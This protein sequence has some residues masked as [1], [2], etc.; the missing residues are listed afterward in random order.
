MDLVN[1]IDVGW[2]DLSRIESAVR[3]VL[4]RAPCQDDGELSA[5]HFCLWLMGHHRTPVAQMGTRL[6]TDL[7]EGGHA[8]ATYYLATHFLSGVY[9]DADRMRANLMLRTLLKNEKLSSG[10]RGRVLVTLGGSLLKGLGCSPDLKKALDLF[11]RAAELGDQEACAMAAQINANGV[12]A[13]GD[14]CHRAP[15]L[16]RAAHFYALGMRAGNRECTAM[17]GV[18]HAK[19]T[20][21]GADREYGIDLL[22]KAAREGDRYAANALFEVDPERCAKIEA[23]EMAVDLTCLA[24]RVPEHLQTQEVLADLEFATICEH[25][26]KD[27]RSPSVPADVPGSLQEIREYLA[28]RFHEFGKDPQGYEEWLSD[29]EERNQLANAILVIYLE[30]NLPALDYEVVLGLA[31][32]AQGRRKLLDQPVFRA[33]FEAR[34]K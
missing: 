16:Q 31:T 13:E 30:G 17:L 6:M 4:R 9:P 29:M 27:Q 14:D 8:S 15:D 25:V 12:C 7:S 20:I 10:D 22:E 24:L 21:T 26:F 3:D 2:A 1:S 11:E 19:G 23:M 28:R 33:Y 32:Y 18:L 34:G 5:F